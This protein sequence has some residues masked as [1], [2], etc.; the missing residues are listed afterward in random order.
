MRILFCNKY[1]FRFSG[2]EAYLFDLMDLLR[3]NGH[4][5]AL[6]SM[7][8]ER[9]LATEYQQS[10]VPHIDFKNEPSSIVA[11]ARLAAHVLYSRQARQKLRHVIREFQPDVAHIRNIYHHLSPSILWELRAHSVPILYHV[12]DFKLICP[13]YNLVASG[14]AC[15]RCHGGR[16][17]NVVTQGCYPQSRSGSLL[18]AAEAYLHKWLRTYHACVTRFLTPSE[19]ARQKLAEN[20]WDLSKIDVLHHFQHLPPDSICDP[21]PDAPILYLGRLSPEKGV[22]DLLHALARTPHLPLEIAGDGPA[23]RDLEDLVRSLGLTGVRFLGRIGAKELD[24]HLAVCSFTVFPSLAYE[25]FGKTILES[26]AH[27]R[28]VVATDLGSRRELISDGKNGLLYEPGNRDALASAIAYLRSNPMR[29]KEMGRAGYDLVEAQYTPERHYQTMVQLYEKLIAT[30]SPRGPLLRMQRRIPVDPHKLRIAF[31]GG[32]GIVSKYSG[33]ESYYEEVGRRLAQSNHEIT[34]YCRTYFTPPLSQKENMRIVR[35]PTLRAKHLETLV[36]TALSTGHAIFRHYDLV[37]YHALGP[38]LFS[39]IPRLFGVKTMV[40]VQG[41]D[42]QRRKWGRVAATVLRFG[43]R[44]AVSLPSATT[45]VSRTLQD[46]YSAKYGRSTTFI[47][48]GA[49]IRPRTD[50]RPLLQWNLQPDHYIL[51]LGRFSPE[52]NCDLLIRAFKRIDTEVVLVLAGG[53]SH[54]DDY[55][56][57]LRATADDRIRILDWVSGEALEALLTNAL[58]FVLPSD[59]EGLSLALLDAMGAAT[60]VLT[61]DIPENRE[62]VDGVGFTFQKGNEEDLARM[63][64]LL[65]SDA[66]MRN[67]AGL[68]GQRRIREQYLWPDIADRIEQEYFRVLDRPLRKP[69]TTIALPPSVKKQMA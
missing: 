43:E 19:F 14:H 64:K 38:A 4:E 52:K 47:P 7:A 32:R 9:G 30:K 58:L 66:A 36:H 11:G 51:Y 34:I 62:L 63:L 49:E 20:G 35:L 57:A 13:S 10:L 60:C 15:D 6:F 59:L 65:T 68:A 25:T 39:F 37:H 2:T 54:S 17:W 53:S 27:G 24:H 50:C 40:T 16:F 48:N 56:R 46:M 18:L 67:V 26:W 61:S 12:N 45:V 44:A 1:N 28:T 8:D 22:A 41:L 21:V 5:V 3:S 33:I 42:W 69:P 55:T 29:A 23:R 31:I